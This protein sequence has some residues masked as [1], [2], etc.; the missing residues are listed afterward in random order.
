MF[1]SNFKRTNKKKTTPK[2]KSGKVQ[3][4]NFRDV[5]IIR[6]DSL[7]IYVEVPRIG[8]QHF[9]STEDIREFIKIIPKWE[10]ISKG[11]D[12]I[13]LAKE[14]PDD[15][16][17]FYNADERKIS[18][19][20]WQQKIHKYCTLGYFRDHAEI[21]KILK[22]PCEE[23]GG[24]FVFSMPKYYSKFLDREEIHENI[25]EHL[26]KLYD[27]YFSLEV[28]TLKLGKEWF[29]IDRGDQLKWHLLNTSN[30]IDVYE[31]NY[32]CKFTVESVKAYQLMHIFLHE[33]GHH[34]DSIN[35]PQKGVM[36]RDESYA[37]QY[38][39]KYWDLI[40]ERYQKKFR[41]K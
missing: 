30:G 12:E 32:L 2:V 20:A 24:F 15:A 10:M 16:D 26:E 21:F 9:L 31:K 34:Y 28:D 4:K 35:T 29:L 5:A 6:P 3:R 1:R 8:F 17:G 41:Y 25:I 11:L 7:K 38:A 39:S 40:W 27:Y 23:T 14:D 36:V 37:E 33:L 13:V 18:I 19:S 22:I